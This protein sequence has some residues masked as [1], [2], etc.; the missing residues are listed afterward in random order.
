MTVVTGKATICAMRD[1]LQSVPRSPDAA[2][3]GRGACPGKGGRNSRRAMTHHEEP[4]MGSSIPGGW[5][6]RL[7]I[8]G[9]AAVWV[10]ASCRPASGFDRN[11]REVR[12]AVARAIQFLE[13]G[14]VGDTRPGAQALIGLALYK[15]GAR[16]NHPRIVSAVS[17]L[18]QGISRTDNE[19]LVTFDI[20]STALAVV[21][22]A[23]LDPNR[24]RS[25]VNT[26][27]SS[28][29]AKQKPHGGWGYPNLKTGDT[30]MTQNAVLALWEA[31]KA[32]FPVPADMVDRAMIWLLKTQDPSGGFGYQGRAAEDFTPIRQSQVKPS[33]S[34]AGLG[35][36]YVCADFL[37]LGK[38]PEK[39]QTDLPPGLKEVNAKKEAPPPR[40]RVDPLLVHRALE[41]GK[42]WMADNFAIEQQDYHLYNLYTV[43]R[44]HTFREKADGTEQAEPGWYN[45]G[46]RYLLKNQQ[47]DGSWPGSTGTGGCGPVPAT[48]FG[49]LFLIRSTKI[50]VEGDRSYGDGTLIVGRTLPRNTA[51]LTVWNGNVV[52]KPKLGALD[53]V[54]AALDDEAS[55][56]STDALQALAQLPSEEA[57]DLVAKHVKKIKH[58]V[59]NAS[60]DV[61][62]AAVQ[63]LGKN[64]NVDLVPAL[65]YALTDPEPEIVRAARDSLRRISRRFQ[66]FGLPDNPTELEL[67]AAI[68]KWQAWYLAIRPDAD[69]EE[70]LVLPSQTE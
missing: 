9:L 40:S 65:I 34:A 54:L 69:L 28:L 35:S 23:T 48:A 63:A 59:A 61:R 44:Y 55:P 39:K 45:D 24:Y 20:Y 37:R 22:L 18:Q 51:G 49:I 6:L 67:Q 56:D 8:A 41:R 38:P 66:G 60:A 5:R 57:A 42:G 31:K 50:S 2:P 12:E 58:L 16:P 52:S 14:E 11:S 64:R 10:A 4:R 17:Q 70:W 68:R 25:E 13:K 15:N 26:L 47:D 32:G 30:S 7:L 46:V 36:L 21:F 3:L 43:E 29:R 33:M 27:L 62:L 1:C 19:G 53:Q